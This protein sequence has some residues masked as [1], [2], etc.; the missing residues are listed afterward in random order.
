MVRSFEFVVV[1]ARRCA[2]IAGKLTA[3]ETRGAESSRA[4]VL[5]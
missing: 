2:R 3:K 5:V 1:V 4:A